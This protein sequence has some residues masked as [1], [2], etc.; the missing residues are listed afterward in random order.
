MPYIKCRV[1]V[2]SPFSRSF[3]PV[4]VHF[5]PRRVFAEAAASIWGEAAAAAAAEKQPEKLRN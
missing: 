1:F 2:S 4:F 3:F 5:L